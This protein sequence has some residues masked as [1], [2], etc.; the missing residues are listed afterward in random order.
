MRRCL[1][2]FLANLL[3]L[4]TGRGALAQA[5]Q[6]PT[7]RYF[8]TNTTVSVPD[9]GGASLGGVN[10]ASSGSTSRGFGP[11]RNRASGS[12]VSASGASVH[13]TIIDLQEM[14]RQVLAEAAQQRVARGEPLMLRPLPPPDPRADALSKHIATAAPAGSLS[15]IRAAANREQQLLEAEAAEKLAAGIE[16]ESAGKLALARMHYAAALRMN[17]SS[18]YEE[19]TA[20]LAKIA[21]PKKQPAIYRPR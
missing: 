7:F 17:V 15:A 21:L 19:A 18:V 1:C 16:A 14:D 12:S 8:T 9:G 20:R 2:C 10:R 6:L 5:V 13:A 3:F 4:A 11:L